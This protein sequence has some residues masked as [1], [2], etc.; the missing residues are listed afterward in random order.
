MY[1][2]TCFV[3]GLLKIAVVQGWVDHGVFRESQ[4]VFERGETG[5]LYGKER[6]GGRHSLA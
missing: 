4:L 1:Y 6:G 3:K 2:L 5:A